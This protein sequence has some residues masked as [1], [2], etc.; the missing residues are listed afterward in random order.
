[1][2]RYLMAIPVIV[3]LLALFLARPGGTFARLAPEEAADEV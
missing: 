1:M 3:A 2:R